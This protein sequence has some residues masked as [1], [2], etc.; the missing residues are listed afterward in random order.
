MNRN[1]MNQFHNQDELTDESAPVGTE[2]HVIYEA[3][4]LREKLPLIYD[5][6]RTKKK[7]IFMKHVTNSLGPKERKLDIETIILV[8]KE[9]N[10]LDGPRISL[11]AAAKKYKLSHT[12][13][14]IYN[15]RIIKILRNNDFVKSLRG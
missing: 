12:Q 8:F 3:I 15:N 14:G 2:P 5:I 4:E 9:I 7:L 11:R 13:I 1:L 10:G 6:I